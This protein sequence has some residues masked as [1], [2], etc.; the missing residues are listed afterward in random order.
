ME[1]PSPADFWS[2]LLRERLLLMKGTA[3][4]EVVWRDEKLRLLQRRGP[5]LAVWDAC[6]AIGWPAEP[7]WLRLP[8]FKLPPTLLTAAVKL[9]P[10][11]RLLLRPLLTP[12]LDTLLPA[13]FPPGA[14]SDV[15]SYVSDRERKQSLS[16][17]VRRTQS[18]NDEVLHVFHLYL[19]FTL[20]S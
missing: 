11:P 8:L 18:Q 7:G 16:G 17:C 3:E 4:R 5:A 15:R 19:M 14:G 2:S 9:L 6:L 10:L 12:A 1:L 13:C 20:P